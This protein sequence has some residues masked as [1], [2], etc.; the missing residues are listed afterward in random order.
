[1]TN[2]SC[3]MPSTWVGTSSECTSS[4][5]TVQQH[6]AAGTTACCRRH[7]HL[8]VDQTS[9]MWCPTYPENP[10][11]LLDGDTA[12]QAKTRLMNHVINVLYLVP[13]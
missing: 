6:S 2:R 1:M 9:R 10:L 3:T 13:V 12:A 8:S 5:P 11:S 4:R 7:K